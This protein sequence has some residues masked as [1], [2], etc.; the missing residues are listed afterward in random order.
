MFFS[1]FFHVFLHKLRKFEKEE[2]RKRIKQ[3]IERQYDLVF[4]LKRGEIKKKL[5]LGKEVP[6]VYIAEGEEGERRG[7]NVEAGNAS[8]YEGQKGAREP[9]GTDQNQRRIHENC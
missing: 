1:C 7:E 2:E 4:S 6:R 8:D 3:E 5:C 9:Q